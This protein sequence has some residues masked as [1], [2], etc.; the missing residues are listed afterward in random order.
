MHTELTG[1]LL[2]EMLRRGAAELE[3]NIASINALNVFPVPDGDTGTNMALTLS[4]ALEH[5]G[6]SDVETLTL[7]DA[8][9]QISRGVLLGAR[10]NSGV[11]LSQFLRGFSEGVAGRREGGAEDLARAL[12]QG[13]L[14]AYR[15]V[16]KPVEGTMLTVG[17]GASTAAREAAQ[18]GEDLAGV[19]RAATEGAER[20]LAKTPEQLPVLKRAG[21][22]DAGGQGFLCFLQG[23]LDACRGTSPAAPADA[24]VGVSARAPMTAVA[25]DGDQFGDALARLHETLDP[26]EITYRYC[27]EFLIQGT[28]LP[29]DGIRERLLALGDSLLVVGD[30]DLVKVHVHTE[31][32]GLALEIGV[33]YG[34][35]LGISIDNMREQQRQVAAVVAETTETSTMGDGSPAVVGLG[36]TG[37]AA[38][39]AN[40]I[41]VVAVAQGEGWEELLTSLGVDR[42]VRGGQTMNPSAAELLEAIDDVASPAVV[43]LPNNSNVVFAARQAQQLSNRDVYVV[44][45]TSPPAGVAALMAFNPLEPAADVAAT[46]DAAARRVRTA[47]I[48]YAVRDSDGWGDGIKAGDKLGIV[49]GDIKVVAPDAKGATLQTLETLV[50]DDMSFISIYYGEEVAQGEAEQLADAVGKAWP[51]CEVELL[52]GGQP[53]YYYL[54]SVE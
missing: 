8:A 46:M 16:I 40:E 35:L 7:S 48:A 31:N 21:V 30:E 3:R 42:I 53:V 23:A 50:N 45:T 4:S 6:G 13:T 9:K 54:L 11:I 2:V 33:A 38:P 1:P 44:E 14:F 39:V 29:V 37:A 26:D 24:D 32:P 17:K 19:L 41:G 36:G 34:D 15:A 5:V 22:V 51:H 18:A 49:E 12:E 10:G 28:A 25:G 20:A 52:P 27:T 47:E 43:I